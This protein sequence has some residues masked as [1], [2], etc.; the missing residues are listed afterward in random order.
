MLL[1]LPTVSPRH[2]HEPARVGGKG[3]G[4]EEGRMGLDGGFGTDEED[5][6]ASRV[7]NGGGN[8]QK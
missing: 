7:G 5:E 1:L 6:A 2:R 3:K 8:D 4:K